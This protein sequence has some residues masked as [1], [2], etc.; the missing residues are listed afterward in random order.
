MAVTVSRANKALVVPPSPGVHSMFPNAPALPDG[1]VIVPH[2]MRETLL[3]RHIGYKVPNP[4]LLYYDWC[5]GNPFHVQKLTCKLLSESAHAYVLNHMG[6]GKTKTALWAWDFL[7]KAGL[8]GKLLVVAPL[9]T[10]HFVWAREVFAT[11]PGRKVQV[12]HGSKQDRLDRL[13]QDADVYVINHDGVKVISDALYT[14]PDITCLVLDELAVYRNNSDRSKLMRKFAARFA[15]VWGMTGAPMPNEP[16]DVWGQARIVTPNTVPKYQSHA[17]DMLMSKVS[18]YVWKPKPDAVEKAFA[19]LQPAVRYS[20]DDVVE[21]PDLISRTVDVDLSDQQKA[22]YESVVKEYTALV[23]EHRITAL[24]AGAAMTKLLQVA[25]G[26][27]YTQKPD[28]VRLDASPRV[29]ALIDLVQS[30]ERKVIAFVP[31]RHMI[32]GLGAIFER[33]KVGF[34]YCIVHGDTTDRD[35]IFHIFQNSPDKFKLMLAHPATV[36]HG[37]T[38]TAAD[39]TIWY[40]PT[41]SLDVYDQANARFRRIGQHH[42]QQLIHMQATPVEKKLY[43]LLASKQKIQEKLLEMIEDATARRD[44][45]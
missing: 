18:Q 29:A 10:L 23:K 8:T 20:L 39:T 32:E 31:Y 7:N 30:A 6:T 1:N 27:V 42:K 36:H 43:R 12:L 35:K 21:L 5:G 41:A 24:N 13:A 22:V 25:G 15:I 3:L 9:S 2:G 19:M 17:R 45:V 28:F 40:L 33:L 14:R 4:M 11:L 44:G 26:W 34:D 38:L 16:T 37:L